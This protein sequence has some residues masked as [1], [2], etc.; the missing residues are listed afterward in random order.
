[1]RW[2]RQCYPGGAESRLPSRKTRHMTDVGSTWG[3]DWAHGELDGR[4]SRVNTMG[5][6]R[7]IIEFDVLDDMGE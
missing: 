6:Q 2:P 7:V 5:D 1:M 3:S 4:C